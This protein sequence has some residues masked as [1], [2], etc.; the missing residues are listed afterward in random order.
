MCPNKTSATVIACAPGWYSTGDATSCTPCDAGRY[1]HFSFYFFHFEFLWRFYVRYFHSLNLL[2]LLSKNRWQHQN[3]MWSGHLVNIKCFLMYIL[4]S[5]VCMPTYW[6]TNT[7]R[8][9]TLIL[10]GLYDCTLQFFNFLLH[11]VTDQ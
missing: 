5:R 6:S 10:G 1:F 2:Q 9:F 3:S 4:P 8:F 7:V 11:K